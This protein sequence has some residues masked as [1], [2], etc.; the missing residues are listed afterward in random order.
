[1]SETAAAYAG[2]R[3]LVTGATGF[4]GSHLVRALAAAGAETHTLVRTTRI[5]SLA[6]VDRVRAHSCDLVDAAAVASVV[7]T[8]DPDLVFHLAAYGT[9]GLQ[10]DRARIERVNIAGTTNLWDALGPRVRRFVHTGTCAEYGDVRGPIPEAHVCQPRSLYAATLHAAVTI[11]Q[12]RG[13][14]SGREVVILRP[15][16]PYGAGDRPER[17]IPYV[18]ARLLAGERA[19]V[20]RGDQLRDYSHVDDHVS[21]MLLA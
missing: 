11:S 12:A 4:L 7:S 17:L 16:G 18:I 8:V 10:S 13:L 19:E 15:F 20:T 9:T 14:E 3:V 1:M 2:L 21:A 6:P 5:A